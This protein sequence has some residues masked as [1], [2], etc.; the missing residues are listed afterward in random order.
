VRH[1]PLGQ[2]EGQKILAQLAPLI[3][4]VGAE[5]LQSTPEDLGSASFAADMASLEHETQT[6]RIFRS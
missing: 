5:A 3:A 1:V 2:S 4:R 6:T